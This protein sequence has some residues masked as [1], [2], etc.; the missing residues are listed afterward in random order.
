MDP[1]LVPTVDAFAI[2]RLMNVHRKKPALVVGVTTAGEPGDV[3]VG[4]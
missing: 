3:M 4:R 2:D 1:S